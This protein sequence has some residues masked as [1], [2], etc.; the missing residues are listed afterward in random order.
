[1]CEYKILEEDIELN[2]HAIASVVKIG[3]E[4]YCLEP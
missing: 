1:M 2:Y 3:N 4:E